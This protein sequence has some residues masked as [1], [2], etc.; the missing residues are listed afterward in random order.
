MKKILLI[1]LLSMGLAL[2]V[3]AQAPQQFNYQGAARNTNGTPLANKNISLR[4]SIIDAS[5]TGTTQY[6]EVRNVVTNV[7]GLYAV[8][9]GSGGATAVTGTIGGVT[10]ASGLKF[11]KVEIDPDNGTNFTLA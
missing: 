7:L 1:T 4:I 5:A 9:I 8:A 10:W 2:A 11:V 3:K 6:S